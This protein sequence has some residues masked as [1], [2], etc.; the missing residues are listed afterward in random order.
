MSRSDLLVSEAWAKTP[1]GVVAELRSDAKAG[2]SHEEAG[3]RLATHGQNVLRQVK[4]R[5]AIRPE[6]TFGYPSSG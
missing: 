6:R 5:S 3:K 4:R 2:L 1:E